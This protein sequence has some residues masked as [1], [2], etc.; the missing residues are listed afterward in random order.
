MSILRLQLEN[1]KYFSFFIFIL[2]SCIPNENGSSK[3]SKLNRKSSSK[4]TIIS[5][6][7]SNNDS[8][9]FNLGKENGL[10]SLKFIVDKVDEN[11]LRV[12]MV[13]K[14]KTLIQTIRA[15]KFIEKKRFE[16]IDWNFD[17][18]KDISVQ[19]ESASGGDSYWIWN[20]SPIAKKYFYN[21]ILSEK[22][23]LE[24]DTKSKF[25]VFHYRA[26][27]NEES[28]DTSKYI[29]NKLVFV[30]GLFQERWNDQKG[31]SWIKNTRE[32]MVHGIRKRTSDSTILK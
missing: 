13:Y 19:I 9:V 7:K 14:G 3:L 4:E 21:T 10:Y 29:K 11:L 26:G 23:G 32:K 20:Y 28:W 5:S 8:L 31:N 15:N 12:I 2:V 17:G 18:Y 25:I 1:L 27:Y 16:L 30:K 24:I 22:T 6:Q